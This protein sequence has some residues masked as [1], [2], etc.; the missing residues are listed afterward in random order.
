MEQGHK[1]K[2]I[3]RKGTGL[4]GWK[5]SFQRTWRWFSTGYSASTWLAQFFCSLTLALCGVSRGTP[6]AWCLLPHSCW[7]PAPFCAPSARVIFSE[8][9]AYVFQPFSYWVSSC[10]LLGVPWIVWVLF[11]HWYVILNI[12]QSIACFFTILIGYFSEQKF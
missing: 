10:W 2:V 8:K 12:C 4:L 6:H 5:H 7:E 3:F 11:P 9:S 1:L